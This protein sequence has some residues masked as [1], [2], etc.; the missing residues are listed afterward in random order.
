MTYVELRAHSA[1]SFGDGTTSPEALVSRAADLGYHALGLT[2]T[3]DLGGIIRFTLEAERT[4]IKPICGAE[5]KVEGFPTAFLAA[6]RTGYR[7]LAHLVTRSRVG[8]IR[9]WRTNVHEHEHEYGHV[10][11]TV[12]PK[13]GH[14]L[15]KRYAVP[16]PD[17]GQPVLTF[18]PVDAGLTLT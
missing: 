18:A 16:L 12:T 5:L 2:D 15:H 6:D 1:F 7:N 8:S 4:G 17:R 14:N 10:H 9:E 11:G 13:R 3:S